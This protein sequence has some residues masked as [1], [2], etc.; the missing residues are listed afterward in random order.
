MSNT[1]AWVGGWVG[2][3]VTCGAG[4]GGL[5]LWA[6]GEDEMPAGGGPVSVVRIW[7]EG[8]ATVASECDPTEM[9]HSASSGP[10]VGQ[11]SRSG[12]KAAQKHLYV[13][14]KFH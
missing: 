11:M 13:R 14:Q 10:R 4:E 6:G 12:R 7:I 8:V 1:G 5:Q 2:G 3:W 9:L